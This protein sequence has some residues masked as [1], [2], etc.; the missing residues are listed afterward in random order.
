VAGR[1]PPIGTSFFGHADLPQACTRL[2]RSVSLRY[3]SPERPLA[4]LSALPRTLGAAK[5][6]VVVEWRTKLALLQK[7]GRMELRILLADA[8]VTAQKMGKR[9]LVAAGY[10][11]ITVSNGLAAVKQI[12][13]LHPDIVLLDLYLPGL[14]GIEVCE[15]TKAAPET[16]RMPVVLTVG[17]VDPFRADEGLRVK[18]DGL[19]IKPFEVK[20]LIS[21]VEKLAQRLH[22]SEEPSSEWPASETAGAQL[23]PGAL[24]SGRE[25]SRLVPGKRIPLF[26]SDQRDGEIC[27]VCGH[28][29][30]EPAFACQQCDI[31]L[32]R[33]AKSFGTIACPA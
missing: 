30:L 10:D 15:K 8:G 19:I 17:R 25:S 7:D 22:R 5:P 29:N 27:D 1:L 12:A 9:I 6:R 31:P 20:T 28:L 11:A 14:T 33:N 13:A 23:P 24:S 21:T 3:L 32:T 4:I 18:A 26:S 2:G 16:E